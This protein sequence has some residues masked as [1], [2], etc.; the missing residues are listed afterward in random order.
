MAGEGVALPASLTER[1]DAVGHRYRLAGG[2]ERDARVVRGARGARL[3]RRARRARPLSSFSG[4]WLMR[5]ELAKLLL[6]RP[7]V[8]LLDEPTNHL[9]LPSIRFF[10]ETLER[11]PGAVV[12]VSH[13]RTFLRRQA[14]RIVELDGLGGVALYEG[15]YDDYLRERVARREELLA[16]KAN[17]DRQIAEM[18][19]FVER[20][21]AQATKARQAQSRLKA[22]ERI[23]RI[24]IEPDRR[25]HMRSAA[26]RA[27]RARAS[28][29]CR[30]PAIH[31]RYGD[32]PIYAGVDLELLRG[33]RVALAGPNG[34][35]KSTLPADRRRRAALR[36]GHP[37]PRPQ[38]RA[39]LLR[40]APA[41][42]P[43]PERE[44]SSRRSS[45]A[46]ASR[47]SRA[48][49]GLL[50][51]AALQRRRRREA[52]RRPLGR[53]EG[54]RR[55]GEAAAP[56]GKSPD[57]RRADQPSRHRG[58]RGPRRRLQA[59]S[60]GRCSSSPTTARSSMP[61]RPA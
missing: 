9:D 10:E 21:R 40:P 50:G 56:T 19:R 41:R 49:A 57:P 15:N 26:P 7:D 8:L 37:D 18:E 29:S 25:K 35:G 27:A 47:T 48:C 33:E 22:L 31:K 20:F 43:R 17:Q 61:W 2:F 51:R 12:V 13:D 55:A 1:Y 5:V 59:A 23:E 16:R 45:A 38:R 28:A 46:P 32:E 54:P 53:R 24:E 58:L 14:N 6:A 52:D 3:R 36:R 4:G 11:F 39:R 60:R 44:R 30:S 42:G 34:A